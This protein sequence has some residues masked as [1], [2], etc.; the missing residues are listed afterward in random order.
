ML[1]D[2]TI[3]PTK[4]TTGAVRFFANIFGLKVT[5]GRRL[6]RPGPGLLLEMMTVPETAS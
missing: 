6:L 4:S 5:P 3:V 2:H 1:L